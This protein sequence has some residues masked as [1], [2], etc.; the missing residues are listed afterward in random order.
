[1]RKL[2]TLT[3]TLALKALAGCGPAEAPHE[4]A[5]A[6]VTLIEKRPKSRPPNAKPE[7]SCQ[8]Q[9]FTEEDPGPKE[10]EGPGTVTGIAGSADECAGLDEDDRCSWTDSGFCTCW[11]RADGRG[12]PYVLLPGGTLLL[13][14]EEYS[15]GTGEDDH[16]PSG[17][18]L[19]VQVPP[20]AADIWEVPQ[21]EYERF[22]EE[23]THPRP[24]NS[25]LEEHYDPEHRAR[26]PVTHVSRQDMAEPVRD[27]PRRNARRPRYAGN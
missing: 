25:P 8:D 3:G 24:R 26:Y 20:I 19:A 13:P 22:C 14:P 12:G 11:E 1:M 16:D 18:L 9:T 7:L 2:I 23:T 5:R 17:Q 4:L 6:Q 21:E 15:S 27:P 10:L